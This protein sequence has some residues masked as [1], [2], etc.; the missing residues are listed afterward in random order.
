LGTGL[1]ERKNEVQGQGEDETSQDEEGILGDVRQ[2]S[3]Y[4]AQN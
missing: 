3:L 4:F 2:K 1:A